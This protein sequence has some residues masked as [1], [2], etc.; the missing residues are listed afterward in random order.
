MSAQPVTPL[1]SESE[2]A[3][4]EEVDTLGEV[5]SFD[6]R[7]KNIFLTY[8]RCSL[9]PAEVYQYLK[10]KCKKYCPKFI[11]VAREAHED[12]EY[13]LHALVQCTKFL[14]TRSPRFFDIAS[15]HPNAQAARDPAKALDYCMKNPLEFH[16]HGTFLPQKP[17]TPKASTE[18]S[19]DAKMKCIID[20]ATS[21][22]EYLSMVRK[23]FPFEW[24][25]RLQ[26]FEYSASRLFPE[27]P[28][29]YV[30]PYEHPPIATRTQQPTVVDWLES[31]L[32]SVSP[33]AYSVHAGVSEEQARIDLRWMSDVSRTENL[34]PADEASTSVGQQEL[35]RLLGPE[36]LGLI[37][38]GSTQ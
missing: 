17:R 3:G 6:L 18:A 30:S 32:Y 14:R 27:V 1:V 19:K 33:F 15:H 29:V 11:Y 23:A 35:E 12:G 7:S 2:S 37:T 10:K 21:K 26:Q 38:T 31:E 28:P 8:P 13:H 34:G 16:K 25:V 4:S 36:V 24:A 9:H 22:A 5:S 20:S